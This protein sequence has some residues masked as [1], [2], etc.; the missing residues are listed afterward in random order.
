[1]H[2]YDELNSR[3]CEIIWMVKNIRKKKKNIRKKVIGNDNVDICIVICTA[4]N[5]LIQLIIHSYSHHLWSIMCH[6]FAKHPH[7]S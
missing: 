6:Q 2:C 1:M 3:K 5:V 4:Q 7:N